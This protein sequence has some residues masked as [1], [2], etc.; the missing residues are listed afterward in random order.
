MD[1]VIL[2][3]E[4]DAWVKTFVHS[5]ADRSFSVVPRRCGT[6]WTEPATRPL[7]SFNGVEAMVLDDDTR[8][9]DRVLRPSLLAVGF[10]RVHVAKDAAAARKLLA[11]RLRIGV[12]IVSDSFRT[13]QDVRAVARMAGMN[14][15]PLVWLAETSEFI[16][17]DDVPADKV[18]SK[19]GGSVLETVRTI[20]EVARHLKLRS[21]A[22][23]QTSALCFAS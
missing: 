14:L 17:A 23:R 4:K 6:L 18:L 8:Y 20:K 16:E 2:V 22:V 12:I 9:R 21:A 19:K 13:P 7:R 11:R 15:I 3:L 5:L 10:A 1:S